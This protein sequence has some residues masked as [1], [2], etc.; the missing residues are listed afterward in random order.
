MNNKK[1]NFLSFLLGAVLF[2]KGL[3]IF[4]HIIYWITILIIWFFK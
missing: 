2:N 3:P 1:D 4:W